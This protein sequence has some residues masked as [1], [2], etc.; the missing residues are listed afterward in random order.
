MVKKRGLLSLVT[1]VLMAT[2]LSQANASLKLYGT[3]ED[4]WGNKIDL[5][6]HNKGIVVIYPLSTSH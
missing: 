6:R 3:A 2:L 4:L 1:F 5:S